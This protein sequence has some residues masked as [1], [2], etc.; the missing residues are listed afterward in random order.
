MTWKPDRRIG[1]IVLA[2]ALGAGL[3]ACDDDP[4]SDEQV[5]DLE[6]MAGLYDVGTITFDPQ[7]SA[8]AAD[9]LAA[10]EEAGTSPTLNIGNTGSFQLFFR[11]P[12]SG[13]VQTLNG[14]AEP[15]TTGVD[16]RFPTQATADLFLF[17]LV[18]PLTFDE[19][20][21]TL[22][23]AGSAQVSRSRLQQLYPELYAEEQLFD[24]TPGFLSVVFV[25][26]DDIQ[27]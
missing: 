13:N 17:P 25:P 4:T 9:V 11:D 14:T 27:P 23:F 5:L 19:A 3:A 18:L 20:E 16:L 2:V 8:P 7:G 26:T 10:L 1:A 6:V 24:P 22:A 15:T 12:A 21:G